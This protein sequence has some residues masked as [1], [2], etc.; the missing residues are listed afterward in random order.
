MNFDDFVL[1]PHRLLAGI[2]DADTARHFYPI[3]RGLQR[4]WLEFVQAYPIT[5]N[6]TLQIGECL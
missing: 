2:S 4:A 1:P 3:E 5:R 6:T